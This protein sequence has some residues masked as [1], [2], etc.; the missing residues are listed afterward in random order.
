[1]PQEAEKAF[2]GDDNTIYEEMLGVFAELRAQEA[3]LRVR[4]NR[5]WQASRSPMSY[6]SVIAGRRNG[7]SSPVAYEYDVRIRQV[8]TGLGFPDDK[9]DLSLAAPQRRAEDACAS[10]AASPGTTGSAHP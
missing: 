6:S 4:W 8:L 9:W 10:S 7:L 5:R 2:A 3:E 1:L